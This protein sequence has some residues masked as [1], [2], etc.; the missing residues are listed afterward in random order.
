MR[1]LCEQCSHGRLPF[2]GS[3]RLDLYA[4]WWAMKLGT[5]SPGFCSS[6]R[7]S[8]PA[9]TR[10]A[11]GAVDV[12]TRRHSSK[13][14]GLWFL[15]HLASGRGHCP[16]SHAPTYNGSGKPFGKRRLLAKGVPR[17]CAICYLK[18]LPCREH[19]RPQWPKPT[20]GRADLCV[21]DETR[22]GQRATS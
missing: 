17:S 16:R 14:D 21:V 19:C 4:R 20:A 2:A 10:G 18:V 7:S 13:C 22:F 12:G 6:A 5:R 15:C 3:P 9:D 8:W 11:A 1:A